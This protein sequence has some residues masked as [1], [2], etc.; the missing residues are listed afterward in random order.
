M[1]S[2]AD[3]QKTSLYRLLTGERVY[4]EYTMR[5]GEA[6]QVYRAGYDLDAFQNSFERAAKSQRHNLELQTTE[7]LSTDRAA[8]GAAL[9]VFGAYTGAVSGMRDAA[10]PTFAVTYETETTEFAALVTEAAPRRVRV[11][12]YNFRNADMEIGLKFWRLQPGH[13]ILSQGELL[14]GEGP[15]Q[16]RY[17]WMEETNVTIAHRADGAVVTVPPG[18]V[19]VVDVRM[20]RPVTVPDYSPDL[21]VSP[22]DTKVSG[23]SVTLTVHNIGNADAGTFTVALQAQ[24]GEGWKTI[25]HKTLTGLAAP[26]DLTPSRA[27]VR[28]SLA[29]PLPAGCRVILDPRDH[30]FEICETNNTAVVAPDEGA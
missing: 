9:T 22:R 13:Y 29:K 28:F 1:L 20:D 6:A 16:H 8:L 27:S 30:L 14:A 12:L 23:R 18:K 3:P 4:D 24:D 19:W 11:W 25:A 17:G 26:K 10:M 2:A 5:M 21:A 15:E 7:V